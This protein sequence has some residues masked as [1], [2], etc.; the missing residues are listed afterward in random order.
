MSNPSSSCTEVD[1]FGFIVGMRS[2][3]RDERILFPFSFE[4]AAHRD[5]WEAALC[6]WDNN[7]HDVPVSEVCASIANDSSTSSPT[8]TDTLVMW[9]LI[10]LVGTGLL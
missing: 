4:T 6:Q 9:A 8:A 2:P 10:G 5:T 7:W 1:D 3:S